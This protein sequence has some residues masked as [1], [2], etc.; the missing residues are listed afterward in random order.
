MS[1]ASRTGGRIPC[2]IPTTVS[3]RVQSQASQWYVW[4]RFAIFETTPTNATA[5]DRLSK[6]VSIIHFSPAKEMTDPLLHIRDGGRMVHTWN[7]PDY[8]QPDCDRVANR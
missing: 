5:C 3:G 2:M 6:H 4:Q 1:N 7:S 8:D